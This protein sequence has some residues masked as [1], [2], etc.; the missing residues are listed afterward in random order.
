[1]DKFAFFVNGSHLFGAFKHMEV[2]VNDYEA[3]YRYLFEQAVGRWRNTIVAAAPPPAQL[4]RVYWY[5]VDSID[6][7]DLNNP[8]TRQYLNERF[9]DDREIRARW[10]GEANRQFGNT[11]ADQ[12]RLEQIAFD[13]CFDDFA[14]WYD[15][16]LNIL[17]GMNRF[18]HAV[19]AASDFI[20]VCRC[21]R[22]KVDLLHK[23]L[24]EK[25]LDV[26]LAVDMMGLQQNYD[27]A[28]VIAP[29]SDPIPSID[30]VKGRG[31]QVGVFDFQR[32][33][34]E[35]RGRAFASQ[36]KLTAD[37]VTTVFESDLVRLGIATKG[38]GEDFG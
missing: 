12:G 24:T 10:M 19:E 38:A 14:R 33:A 18:Y 5:V 4:V 29:D 27:T 2:Y 7:W 28:L 32:G 6:E 17:S 11:G 25:S 1:M 16:K 30:Y 37:F 15:K 9:N 3:L 23:T 8:R 31:K 35:A 21:G 13:M 34:Q 36:L 20:E 22:W 26:W